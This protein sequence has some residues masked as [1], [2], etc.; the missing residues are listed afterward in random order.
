MTQNVGAVLEPW[1]LTLP[2][3]GHQLADSRTPLGHLL[4]FEVSPAK[5]CSLTS[6]RGAHTPHPT[7]SPVGPGT[8]GE[9]VASQS[10]F[11]MRALLPLGTQGGNVEP[12]S[13]NQDGSTGKP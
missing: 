7:P 3:P 6:V 1:Q 11:G 2:S 4:N 13:A 10:G 5:D 9:M 8:L 12:L